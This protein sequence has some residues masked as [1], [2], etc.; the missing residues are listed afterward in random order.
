MNKPLELQ[1]VVDHDRAFARE[2]ER[3]R[4]QPAG[5]DVERARRQALA[6]CIERAHAAY[7]KRNALHVK[8]NGA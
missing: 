8:R 6:D 4:E 5:D 3:I 2:L 1:H 7:A